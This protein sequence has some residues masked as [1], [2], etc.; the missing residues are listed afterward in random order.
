MGRDPWFAFFGRRLFRPNQR[1]S[2]NKSAVVYKLA[3]LPNSIA[4]TTLGCNLDT[5]S[6][7]MAPSPSSSAELLAPQSEPRKRSLFR[8]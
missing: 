3:T 2:P 5:T 6:G 1:D 7:N 4:A 8:R